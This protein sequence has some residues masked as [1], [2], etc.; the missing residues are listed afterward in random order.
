M[1]RFQVR[2]IG[3]RSD[4][5]QSIVLRDEEG[6][7]F[8]RAACGSRAVRITARDAELLMRQYRYSP[9]DDQD[10]HA[11]STIADLGC[12]LPDFPP[13]SDPAVVH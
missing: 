9:V 4:Q 7:Y 11:S 12:P 1:Q 5:P 8:L 2:L 13:E 6:R 10:W 3:R